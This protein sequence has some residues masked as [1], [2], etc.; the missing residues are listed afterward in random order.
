MPVKLLTYRRFVDLDQA[1]T[2]TQI[3]DSNGI[4]FAIEEQPSNLPAMYVGE[5]PFEAK[6][7]VKI[8]GEDFERANLLM[9][10]NSSRAIEQIDQDHYLF[11]FTDQE[12]YEILSK[13]DEWSDLD[14]Q[15]AGKI[16][17]E[18]GRVVDQQTLESLR[19][20]RLQS[21]SK[22]YDSHSAWIVVGYLSALF[23]G[24]LGFLIGWH[25]STFKK[26][27]PDGRRIPA[28][29]AV[30]QRHG[31]IIFFFGLF[32]SLISLLIYGWLFY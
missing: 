26:T 7:L 14:Y 13:P 25:L 20:E 11:S 32:V 28:Y 1:K 4:E 27:L 3:L 2:C 8:K 19:T 5:I 10:D 29:S 17:R 12:L 31:A 6:F 24:L 18:R 9:L 15:L 22:P 23:G 30:A 16:L 21:L